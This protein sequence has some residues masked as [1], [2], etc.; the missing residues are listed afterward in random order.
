[1]RELCALPAETEWVE[2]KRGNTNPEIIGKNISALANGAALHGR[3]FGYLI[4]GVDD[5]THEIVGTTFTPELKDNGPQEPRIRASVSDNC[6]FQFHTVEISDYRVVVLEITPARE[7]PV[8]FKGE[9]YIRV[10]S[11]TKRLN[12]VSQIEGQLWHLLR[13]SNFEGGIAALNLTTKETLLRIDYPSYFDLLGQPLPDGNANILD[14]MRRDRLITRSDAGGWNVTN[15]AAILL[16][17]DLRDFEFLS[18]KRVR[19]IKYEGSGRFEAARERQFDQGY[20]AAFQRIIEHIMNLVPSNEVIERAINVELPMFPEIAVRELVANALIHQE[21]LATGA[22]PLV[23]IFA[24][25]IEITNPGKP[26]VETLRFLDAPPQ[27]RNEAIAALM[28][29]FG[30]CEE[31]GSGIDKVVSLIEVH[32]LPAPVFEVASTSTRCVLFAPKTLPEMSPEDRVRACYWH[33]NLRYVINQSTN[34]RSIRQRFGIPDNRPAQATK[35]L[36]E[37]VAE[38]VIVIAD[39]SVGN[40]SRSYLPFWA[41]NSDVD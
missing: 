39:H 21:F 31:R 27:S 17:R 6:D 29:R 9:P 8:K 15:L 1:M 37:A 14:A 26:L 33:A 18:R 41:A 5:D 35:L 38:G 23:E 4:W 12:T 7:Y 34:N 13:Q 36:N 40:K 11:A 3:L 25:R 10:G 2:F 20:A 24:D 32:Q 19:V 22:G 28:R 30:I 16:A